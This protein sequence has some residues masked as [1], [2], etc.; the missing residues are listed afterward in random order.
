[1]P[2]GHQGECQPCYELGDYVKI[3]FSDSTTQI[4]E[5]MWVRVDHRDD[6]K[7]LVYGV[8]DNEPVN[9]YGGK[10]R[11]G[12]ELAISYDQVREHR[13]PSEFLHKD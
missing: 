10:L 2:E 4:G 3:E 8:L 7:R 1:L 5:W 11:L 6:E 9:E 12:S 13:K